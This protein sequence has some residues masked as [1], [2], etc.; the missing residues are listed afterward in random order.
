M[1]N[2]PKELKIVYNYYE[3]I[4]LNPKIQ[5]IAVWIMLIGII[6]FFIAGLFVYV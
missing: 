2:I 5:K 6:A 3:V 4:L 1:K